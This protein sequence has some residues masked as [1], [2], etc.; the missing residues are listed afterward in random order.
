MFWHPL[1]VTDIL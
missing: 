1:G